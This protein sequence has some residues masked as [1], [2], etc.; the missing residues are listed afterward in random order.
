VG[1]LGIV[2]LAAVMLT[3]GYLW[4][5]L[6]RSTEHEIGLVSEAEA[7]SGEAR[8]GVASNF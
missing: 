5:H 8:L 7:A 3:V 4:G 1:K 6:E 2:F